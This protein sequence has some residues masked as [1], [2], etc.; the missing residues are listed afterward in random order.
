MPRAKKRRQRDP[1]GSE[2]RKRLGTTSPDLDKLT[3]FGLRSGSGK[4]TDGIRWPVK[5]NP[6]GSPVTTGII[7]T[8]PETGLPIWDYV[9]DTRMEADSDRNRRLW[10][11]RSERKVESQEK[12]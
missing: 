3:L 11:A 12:R 8:N 5:A 10:A 9:Y 6:D 1:I 4:L 2:I 7:G